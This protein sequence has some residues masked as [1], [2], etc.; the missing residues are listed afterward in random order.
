VLEVARLQ[1]ALDVEV[2]FGYSN[3]AGTTGSRFADFALAQLSRLAEQPPP[4]LPPNAAVG[5]TA[6]S[7]LRYDALSAPERAQVVCA[8]AAH[9]AQLRAAASAAAAAAAAAASGRAAVGSARLLASEGQGSAEWRRQREGLMTGSTFGTA[10]GMWGERALLDFWEERVGLR[11][12]F[13]GNAA[14]AWGSRTEAV[15]ARAYTRL[16][17]RPVDREVA[18]GVAPPDAPG[19]A[20][21]LGASPDGLL[22]RESGVL[23]IKCPTGRR[24]SDP[25]LA[26]PYPTVPAY[27]VPQLLGLQAVFDKSFADFFVYTA[28]NGCSLWRLPH[29]PQLW[30]DMRGELKQLWLHSVLPARAAVAA[31]AGAEELRQFVPKHVPARSDAYRAACDALAAAVEVQRFPTPPDEPDKEA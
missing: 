22:L 11:A 9:A 17:G 7:F 21:W 16:T 12:P 24:G 13:R 31:G 4:W 28:G 29:R 20:A 19:E 2:D 5:A 15:A 6:G 10:L 3:V 25:A 1:A 8:A 18:L 23:E 30:A 26:V 27:Y 14:T